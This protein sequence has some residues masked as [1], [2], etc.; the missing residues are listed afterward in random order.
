[1]IPKSMTILQSLQME[2]WT[3]MVEKSWTLIFP[4]WM[5]L[6]LAINQFCNI[7]MIFFRMSNFIAI[8]IVY[9]WKWLIHSF[10][11]VDEI[12]LMWLWLSKMLTQNFS[13]LLLLLSLIKILKLKFGRDSEAEFWCYLKNSPLG[14]VVPFSML[15]EFWKVASILLHGAHQ[16]I[17]IEKHGS[18]LGVNTWANWLMSFFSKTFPDYFIWVLWGFFSKLTDMLDTGK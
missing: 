6:Q 4:P 14:P 3:L 10:T 5:V 12:R 16:L 9:T 11:A 18:H 13:M 7:F 2:V 8:A 17:F 15:N 1:M